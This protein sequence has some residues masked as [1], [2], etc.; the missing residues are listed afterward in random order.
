M[1][2]GTTEIVLNDIPENF[3]TSIVY[4][5][6][7]AES[8]SSMLGINKSATAIS[9][10]TKSI[11]FAT[12]D[13]P[14]FLKVGDHLA[15][16]CEASIAQIPSELHSM[17]AQMVACRVLEAIGDTQGLQNALI[18]LKQQKVAAGMLVDSRVDDAPQKIVNRHGLVRTAI[19]SKRFNRR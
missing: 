9:V 13:M 4:D 8:P 14:D 16:S 17:L 7:K 5:F 3:N 19:F 1:C 2:T 18:K 10:A 6:Y 12:D 11:T 15:E